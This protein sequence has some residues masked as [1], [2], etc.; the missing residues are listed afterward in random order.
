MRRPK[1]L[2]TGLLIAIFTSGT[3]FCWTKSAAATPAHDAYVQAHTLN[4]QGKFAEAL[5]LLDKALELDPKLIDA[6]ISRSFAHGKLGQIQ[7]ALKDVQK[8]LDLDSNNEVAYNNRGFL[9]LRLGQYDRAI[10]DFTKA[11]ALN[12]EDEAAWANRA[13]AYWRA[14]DA[15]DALTDCS[16]AIGFGLGDA[17][18]YI[19]RGD[20]L[21]S[22]GEPLRAISDYDTAIGYHPTAAN[23][24][25]EPGEAYYKRAQQRVLLANKDINDSKNIGYPVEMAE[26]ISAFK[27]KIKRSN[28]TAQLSNS[29]QS[30]VQENQIGMCSAL[31]ERTVEIQLKNPCSARLV[32]KLI[33]WNSPYLV[34]PDVHQSTWEIQVPRDKMGKIEASRIATNYPKIGA[35]IVRATVEGRPA[36]ELPETIAGASPAYN[37]A[38][39][40]AGIKTVRLVLES[41]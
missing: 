24:F 26:T 8:A 28:T 36:G 11:V 31:D 21:A 5:P 23:S 22:Q 41:R 29:L 15:D 19:T 20:I 27:D 14:G 10:S 4:A 34:S 2:G 12:P 1:I 37:L 39:Y 18:P 6:Y 35:W 32:S 40:D 33:G 9:Y 25:H 7:K 13:E 3:F 30:A 38:I 17:D 16:R